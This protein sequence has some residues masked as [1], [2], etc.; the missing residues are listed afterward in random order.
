MKSICRNV[1]LTISTS[2]TQTVHQYVSLLS[3]LCFRSKSRK[4]LDTREELKSRSTESTC[5]ALC[6]M[7][8]RL[9]PRLTGL[10][11]RWIDSQGFG[12]IYSQT[13]WDMCW[14]SSKCISVTVRYCI[15]ARQRHLQEG[16]S[17]EVVRDQPMSKNCW[18]SLSHWRHVL[19]LSNNLTFIQS[20]Q[21]PAV[22]KRGQDEC[23]HG[24]SWNSMT[25]DPVRE[26]RYFW[27]LGFVN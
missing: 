1:H 13:C 12:L 27:N 19:Y 16:K 18:G 3:F 6:V 20:E 25:W 7:S 4:S 23:P 10:A 24:S 17:S 9:M 11:S 5:T 22:H 15:S 8:S 21:C 2:R 26:I 14:A